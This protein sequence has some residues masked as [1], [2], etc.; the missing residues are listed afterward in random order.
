[1]Y[2][3]EASKLGL[4]CTFASLHAHIIVNCTSM[5]Q[6][7]P[8]GG[9]D[10]DLVKHDVTQSLIDSIRRLIELATNGQLDQSRPFGTSNWPV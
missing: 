7:L 8:Y 9:S 1:M 3:N 6:C 5:G 10:E 2:A 4:I